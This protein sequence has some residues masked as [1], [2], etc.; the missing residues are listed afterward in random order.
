M[1]QLDSGGVMSTSRPGCTGRGCARYSSSCE[2]ATVTGLRL[3]STCIT[4]S[5]SNACAVIDHLLQGG[6]DELHELALVRL[7][8]DA[9]SLGALAVLL[10]MQVSGAT[11]LAQS[12]QNRL[13]PGYGIA[14]AHQQ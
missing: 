6:V 14:L 8:C 11:V 5:G 12:R 9:E 1:T 10:Q 2:R 4:N 3:R 13:W 7:H